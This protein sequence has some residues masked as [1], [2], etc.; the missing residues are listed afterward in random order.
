M[1]GRR[2]RSTCSISSISSISLR[3]RQRVSEVAGQVGECR[4]VREARKMPGEPPVPRGRTV[5]SCSGV[6]RRRPA[7]SCTP[8]ATLGAVV[9][10]ITRMVRAH[11]CT[12]TRPYEPRTRTDTFDRVRATRSSSGRIIR[13]VHRFRRIFGIMFRRRFS[14]VN[15]H[16]FREFLHSHTPLRVL[17][18][19][20]HVRPL[21]TLV[22]PVVVSSDE[23]TVFA[24]IF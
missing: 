4:S 20:E 6:V 22:H 7:S 14:L 3:R 24:G 16:S 17:R 18:S 21:S 13:R 1:W 10:L 11:F 19:Y 8:K 23:F 9:H 2:R 15:S 12:R 5:V